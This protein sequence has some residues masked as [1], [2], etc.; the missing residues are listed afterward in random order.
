MR[1]EYKQINTC[2]SL[3]P[4]SYVGCELMINRSRLIRTVKHYS[5]LVAL[6]KKFFYLATQLTQFIYG[7]M[8]LEYGK[9]SLGE[10]AQFAHYKG[11]I[12]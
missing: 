11:S 8:A 1:E 9:Q 6:R 12:R 4:V 7:Y 2:T 5:V 3:F 10:I